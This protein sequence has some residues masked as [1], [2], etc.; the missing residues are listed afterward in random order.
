VIAILRLLLRLFYRRIESDGA[1]RVPSSRA[2]VFVLNHPNGLIDP[3]LL[4]SISPKRVSFLAK[5]PLFRMPLL[6]RIVKAIGCIPVYRPQDGPV[7]D[8]KRRETIAAAESILVRGGAIAIFPEGTTHSDSSRRELRPG[9]ARIALLAAAGGTLPVAIVPAGLHYSRKER[10]RSSALILFGEPIEVAS[11]DAGPDG[12]PPRESVARLTEMIDEALDSVTLQAESH[13]VLRLVET[14]ERIVSGGK[15]RLTDR[16]RLRRQLAEGYRRLHHDDPRRLDQLEKRFDAFAAGL[17]AIDLDPEDLTE[18]RRSAVWSALAV[19]LLAA[20]AAVGFLLHAPIDLGIRVV[21]PRLARGEREVL[22]TVKLIAGATFYLVLWIAIGILIGIEAG[23][24]A[25]L[26]GTLALPLCGLAAIRFSSAWLEIR[27][28][29]RSRRLRADPAIVSR[30]E[31]ERQSLLD[32]IEAKA[33]EL[34]V[35]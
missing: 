11:V 14:A 5:A 18:R 27:R 2:V 32:E 34:G 33:R 30:L 26:I 17:D 6:G 10:F 25:G 15:A 4:L 3:L 24:R 29:I 13:N 7:D 31:L 20:P 21:A 35:S 23:A 28:A 12:E 9:A 22:G 19:I 16:V 1:E 8:A